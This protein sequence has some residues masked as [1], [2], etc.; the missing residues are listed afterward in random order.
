MLRNHPTSV[1]VR[2]RWEDRGSRNTRGSGSIHGRTDRSDLTE[3][4]RTDASIK[5]KVLEL[6][7]CLIY[8]RES[9]YYLL[10]ENNM[11][12]ITHTHAWPLPLLLHAIYTYACRERSE[13]REGAWLYV[14]V[15]LA[16]WL[17]RASERLREL[18]KP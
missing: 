17:E 14:G 7:V 8:A 11:L 6:R 12:C 13:G 15:G 18:P 9:R 3:T 16:G 1:F 5:K 2:S 10:G 4:Q